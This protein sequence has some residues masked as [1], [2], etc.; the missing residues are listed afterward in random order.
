MKW[1]HQVRG[2]ITNKLTSPAETLQAAVINLSL[3]Y[4]NQDLFTE[5]CVTICFTW[6]DATEAW[7][8][9]KKRAKCASVTNK[10]SASPASRSSRWRSPSAAWAWA[11]RTQN[12]RSP[13]IRRKLK[14]ISLCWMTTASC[15]MTT[16]SRWWVLLLYIA[17]LSRPQTVIWSKL[18]FPLY[19]SLLICL[20][21]RRAILGSWFTAQP[22]TGAAWRPC[23]GIWLAWT[24]RCCW[25][26]RTCTKRYQ[27]LASSHIL[28]PNSTMCD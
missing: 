25:S 26:S 1:E 7:S 4:A 8:E 28:L 14:K 5:T 6:I 13:S 23:I 17:E 20:H 16:T 2:K 15:S 10:P 12:S 27:L 24:A 19:S 11:R 21:G 9:Q 22:C 3:L 18:L